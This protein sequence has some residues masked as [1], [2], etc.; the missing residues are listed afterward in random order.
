MCLIQNSSSIV[1]IIFPN[2][3]D[4]IVQEVII[5]RSKLLDITTLFWLSKSKCTLEVWQIIGS[6]KESFILY[7]DDGIQMLDQKLNNIL[8][9]DCAYFM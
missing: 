7:G 8:F 2:V 6:V 3:A 4:H 5:Q 1:T 9:N